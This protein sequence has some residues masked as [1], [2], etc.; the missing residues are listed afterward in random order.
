MRL[1][2]RIVYKDGI[3]DETP[4][5]KRK[6]AKPLTNT[7]IERAAKEGG[8]FALDYLIQNGKLPVSK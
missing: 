2:E 4:Q 5:L 1:K 7:M 8:V 6:P 3:S